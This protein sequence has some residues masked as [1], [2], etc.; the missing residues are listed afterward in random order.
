MWVWML[1]V[2]ALVA[3]LV[4]RFAVRLLGL[5]RASETDVL[6]LSLMFGLTVLLGLAALGEDGSLLGA[7]LLTAAWMALF[8][9]DRYVL[10]RSSALRQGGS[11]EPTV[12]V[13]RGKLLEHNLY[14]KRMN[15]KQLLS[16][17]RARN[18]FRLADVEQAI[19]EPDGDLSVLR[20]PQ[21]EPLTRQDL[22]V[23]GKDRGLEVEVICDGQI[24]HQNLKQR[25]LSEKWLRDH[26]RAYDVE[27]VSEVALATVDEN[28]ELYVDKYDDRLLQRRELHPYQQENADATS[29]PRAQ[30]LREK[31]VSRAE[32]NYA[33]RQLQR[34]IKDSLPE[35]PKT[36]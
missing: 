23:T 26:L 11:S 33:E 19:L 15:I 10:L 22:L 3:Y 13:Y 21:A 35:V 18:A 9:L 7:G 24:N 14:R 27:F 25:R 2:R 6:Q 1:L 32:A 8:L 28:N 12:L 4:L 31:P 17:L 16:K 29:S 5:G 30:S 36:Q 20:M 34:S